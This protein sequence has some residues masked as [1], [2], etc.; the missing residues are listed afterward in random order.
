MDTKTLES[1]KHALSSNINRPVTEYLEARLEDAKTNLVSC[2]A[3]TFQS[4]QG[5]ALELQELIK[6]IQ[7]V[8]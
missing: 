7:S 4:W 1:F 6:V 8:K 3:N 2:T 5:R